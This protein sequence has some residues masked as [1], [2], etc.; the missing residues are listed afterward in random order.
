M[1]AMPVDIAQTLE[2]VDW[3]QVQEQVADYGPA[4]ETLRKT[5][6]QQSLLALAQG[7]VF[8]DD[9]TLNAAIAKQVPEGGSVQALK[10]QAHAN[11]RMDITATTARY[12]DVELSGTI[13]EFVHEGDKSYMV[14]HVRS[15]NIP[16]HGL[17][18]WIFSRVSLGMAQRFVGDLDLP[19][20]LPVQ[21]KRN[22][23]RIDYSQVLAT[24]TFG[25][26]EF[27][28]HKLTD[29]LIIKSATPKEGGI[30]FQT[31]LDVP[32]DV[33]AALMRVILAGK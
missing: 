26:T 15:K 12:G 8:V 3:A 14:Y 18:S 23:V 10:G 29:M 16:Q 25:Q 24:S 4:I 9:D 20:N 1:I 13:D 30:E 33:Q 22:T 21:I 5:W 32:D 28:G 19:E 7:R 2:S 11:G 27:M 6:D 17:M 31:Q